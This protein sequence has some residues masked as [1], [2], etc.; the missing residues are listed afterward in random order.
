VQRII[1]SCGALVAVLPFRDDAANGFTSKW[2]VQEVQ[3]ARDLV[4]R[5][6]Q[7]IPAGPVPSCA[8]TGTQAKA[9]K[10]P[11]PATVKVEGK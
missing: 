5:C 2:I 4:V 6:R 8:P 1:E 7:K 11:A 9:T 10:R 3:I